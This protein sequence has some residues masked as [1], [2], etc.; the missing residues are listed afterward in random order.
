MD[1]PGPANE[2]RSSGGTTNQPIF[3]LEPPT[4]KNRS[5]RLPTKAPGFGLGRSRFR[6]ES[7]LAFFSVETFGFSIAPPMR[8]ADLPRLRFPD[9]RFLRKSSTWRSTPAVRQGPAQG[10]FSTSTTKADQRPDRRKPSVAEQ[11]LTLDQEKKKGRAK[12]TK[13]RGSQ[14]LSPRIGDLETERA[15]RAP[16]GAPSKRVKKGARLGRQSD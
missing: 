5:G 2:L 7:S 1:R 11:D 9:R 16:V 6:L 8:R 14:E 4:R 15:D 3:R 10:D 12:T 13:G